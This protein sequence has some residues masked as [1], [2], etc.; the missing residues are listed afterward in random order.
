MDAAQE[1][2]VAEARDF[3]LG[4]V[5]VFPLPKIPS[6][7]NGRLAR[8]KPTHG[9]Q[10][11]LTLRIRGHHTCVFSGLSSMNKHSDEKTVQ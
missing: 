3:L 10:K 11:T 6:I 1:P 9:A 8:D 7:R 2:N 5:A 4:R